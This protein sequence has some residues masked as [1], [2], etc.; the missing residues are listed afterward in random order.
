MAARLSM[1]VRILLVVSLALN[2]FV[3]GA[4]V[5]DAAIGGGSVASAL[6]LSQQRPRFFGLPNP[7]EI[8]DLLPDHGDAVLD[9]IYESRRAEFRERLT[10]MFEARRAVAEAIKAEPFDR[11]KLEAAFA[12]LRERSGTIAAAAQDSL[13]EIASRLDSE[14]RTQLA[15]LIATRHGR[16]AKSP[17]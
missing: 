14:E 10:A 12:T 13:I 7:R 3:I 16:P 2:L 9:E 11:A 15:D 4:V 8:R 17:E 1:S 6:G 5:A